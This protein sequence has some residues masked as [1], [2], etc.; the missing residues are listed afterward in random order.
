MFIDPSESLTEQQVLARYRA[1][2]LGGHP[3]IALG[4]LG[5]LIAKNP[6]STRLAFMMGRTLLSAGRYS[7]AEAWLTRGLDYHLGDHRTKN[8]GRRGPLC[9]V[10]MPRSASSNLTKTLA[11]FTGRPSMELGF[12]E[13]APRL[14]VWLQDAYLKGFIEGG[15]ASHSHLNATRA[16]LDKLAGN[17]IRKI[18]V[19]LRDP[20]QALASFHRYSLQNAEILSRLNFVYPGYS[21]LPAMEQMALLSRTYYPSLL[22]WMMQWEEAAGDRSAGIE[23]FIGRFEDMVDEAPRYLETLANFLEIAPEEIPS[24]FEDGRRAPAHDEW[25]AYL[26]LEN[27]ERLD[28]DLNATKSEFYHQK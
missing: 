6:G 11:A 17:G 16:T 19:Q 8:T 21:F 14:D 24:I 15:Y 20:R 22:T 25:R 7:E 1:A 9:I 18:F 10:G 3:D 23:I 13:L 27:Q 5:L 26:K 4:W 12:G 2:R 28:R